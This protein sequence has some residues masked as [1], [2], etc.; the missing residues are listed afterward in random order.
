MADTS[1]WSIVGV[2]NI[3]GYE[4][5]ESPMVLLSQKKSGNDELFGVG[6]LWIRVGAGEVAAGRSGTRASRALR[7][8]RALAPSGTSCT[9]WSLR[10]LRTGGSC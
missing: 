8:L 9:L 7:S 5:V 10:S 3:C 4:G 1:T 2:A 6:D